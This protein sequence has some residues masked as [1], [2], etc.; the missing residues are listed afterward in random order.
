M[1][2]IAVALIS[3][4]TSCPGS[5]RSRA[6]KLGAIGSDIAASSWQ[7]SAHVAAIS[8]TRRRSSP[9]SRETPRRRP[10]TGRD[11]G[12]SSRPSRRRRR[13]RRG[14]RGR[15][16]AGRVFAAADKPAT[17]AET[18][19]R[20]VPGEG[21]RGAGP[22]PQGSVWRRD[23]KPAWRFLRRHCRPRRYG[24]RGKR[25]Y[26]PEVH[27]PKGHRRRRGR[28]VPRCGR[29]PGVVARRNEGR[30][31]IGGNNAQD[32]FRRGACR[33]ARHRRRRLGPELP[34]PS[35][36]ARDPVRGRR[37]DRRA[38]ARD[39]RGDEQEPRPAGRGRERRRRRRRHRL[40]A[41]RP[42]R[43]R[44]LH[45]PPRHGRHPRPEPDPVQ[46]AALQR[47]DRLPAGRPHRR[48]AADPHHPQ[49]L[50]GELVRG[51]RRLFEGEP[52][53]DDLRLGRRRLGDASR[54][55][56]PRL[57]DGHEDPARALPRH[58][59]GDA[60]PARAG[61]STFCARSSR[62]RC[63]RSRAAPSRPSRR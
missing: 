40:A 46:E 28:A 45:L 37:P 52:G 32:A 12:S 21:C 27:C 43:A 9:W 3:A 24:A 25:R 57:G 15:A 4:S 49:G 61:G 2:R 11:A 44:R 59:P 16:P 18:S 50:P 35:D 14:R 26:C 29:A 1:T 38:R 56:P 17:P 39:G 42:R 7:R 5:R 55:R 13:A 51:V 33:R 36:D 19:H 60:G 34:D 63:R 20:T 41:R 22:R 10:E 54:L 53:Q 8:A 58:R 48:G 23:R 62:R 6:E 47:R 31:A 30:P